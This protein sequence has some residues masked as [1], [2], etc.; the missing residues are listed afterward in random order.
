MEIM[1]LEK[2]MIES[3]LSYCRQ[4]SFNIKLFLNPFQWFKFKYY[5][6]ATSR[7]GDPGHILTLDVKLGPIGLLIII[8]DERW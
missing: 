7:F 1:V 8:D 6:T 2:S 4:S 3:I 5:F